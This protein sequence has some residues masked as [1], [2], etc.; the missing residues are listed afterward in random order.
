MLLFQ[1][2]MNHNIRGA[3]KIGRSC[4][5]CLYKNLSMLFFLGTD[6]QLD[7]AIKYLQDLIEDDPRD[8][9]QAPPY[10]DKSVK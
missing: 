10:P 6:S 7:A 4:F 1:D 5:T 9:P 2:K 3:C 8:V